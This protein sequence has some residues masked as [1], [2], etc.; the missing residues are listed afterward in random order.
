[1]M[2][3]PSLVNNSLEDDRKPIPEDLDHRREKDMRR[4]SE[5][6]ARLDELFK[7]W[8]TVEN[9]ADRDERYRKQDPIEEEIL[10][11]FHERQAI[12]DAERKAS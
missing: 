6:N 12:W 5:I 2:E 1:M 4:E 3:V 11:L 7:A 10:E 9:I 8:H